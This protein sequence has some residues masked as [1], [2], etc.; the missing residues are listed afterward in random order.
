MMTCTYD[1]RWRHIYIKSPIISR[2]HILG[3]QGPITSF[4]CTFKRQYF[5]SNIQ[6]VCYSARYDL[7]Q[8][9]I[10]NEYLCRDELKLIRNVV[11]GSKCKVH[12]IQPELIVIHT[13]RLLSTG[14]FW[15][16]TQNSACV[17]LI[18]IQNVL[19]PIA[20]HC[21]QLNSIAFHWIP[22]YS[23]TF[24]YIILH[25]ITFHYITLHYIKFQY[26]T[27][28][29]IPLHYISIHSIQLHF[30]TFHYIT[31]LY[32]TI[33]YITLNY[34]TLIPFHYITFH[35]IILHYITF[36]YI[37]LHFITFQYIPWH[38][39]AFHYITLH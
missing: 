37:P 16:K 32:S 39:I 4:P 35:H 36:H 26:I 29:Y 7:S 12:Y 30:I 31:L 28:H 13:T 2:S 6:L 22:L 21:S 11:T 38:S 3:S 5:F 33:H 17:F 10:K 19:K 20:F 15:I 24:Q 25:S 8:K 23:I 1:F 34:I 14:S 27:L 18:S 9:P